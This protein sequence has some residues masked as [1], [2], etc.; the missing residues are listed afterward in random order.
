[1]D[2]KMYLT[3]PPN[4]GNITYQG[5]QLLHSNPSPSLFWGHTF[6]ELFPAQDWAQQGY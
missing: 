2:I 4:A 3:D 5:P 6:Q 1:M